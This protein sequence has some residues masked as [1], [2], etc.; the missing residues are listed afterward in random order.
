M[1]EPPRPLT[2]LEDVLDVVR[3]Y[4]RDRLPGR[5]AVRLIVLLDDGEEIRLP[6]GPATPSAEHS[7]SA[8]GRTL[9]WFGKTYTFRARS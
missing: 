4:V 9:H 7:L 6:I 3:A 8:D 2:T 1:P 5:K